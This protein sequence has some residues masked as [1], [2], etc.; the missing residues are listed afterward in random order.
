MTS[1]DFILA[2]LAIKNCGECEYSFEHG[3]GYNSYVCDLDG[4]SIDLSRISDLC[5]VLKIETPVCMVCVDSSQYVW[6]F[7]VEPSVRIC[8]ACGSPE[9][10]KEA[11]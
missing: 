9:A 11:A 5:P 4:H 2:R 3:C 1:K 7:S 8:R 10:I 6:N